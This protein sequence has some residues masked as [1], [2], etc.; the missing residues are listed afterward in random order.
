MHNF[1]QSC[2]A[3]FGHPFVQSAYPTL[4]DKMTW[5]SA[6]NAC[7]TIGGDLVIINS[8]AVLNFLR[9]RVPY[10]GCIGHWIGLSDIEMEGTF[11]WVGNRTLTYNNFPPG[12]IQG[13]IAENCVSIFRCGASAYVWHDNPCSRKFSFTCEVPASKHLPYAVDICKVLC[14]TPMS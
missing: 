1:G 8:T 10:T 13:G 4:A 12:H 6:R 9:I 11:R 5:S 14:S 7:M 2:Y 3:H